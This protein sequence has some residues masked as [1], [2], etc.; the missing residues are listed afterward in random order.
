MDYRTDQ[1]KPPGNRSQPFVREADML[2]PIDAQRKRL[3][4]QNSM[5]W[6][7]FF[8]VQTMHGVVD[9]LF[10][11]PDIDAV[12]AR[13][14]VGVPAVTDSA[15]VATLLGLTALRAIKGHASR[16]ASIHALATLVP[17]SIA[18]LRR[19]VLPALV[20][21]GWA[22]QAND[23]AWLTMHAYEIPFKRIIAVEVKR[24]EWR[25]ALA[26][27]IPH[28]EFADTVYV[29]LDAAKIPALPRIEAAFNHAGIGLAAIKRSSCYP[30][31]NATNLEV[32]LRPRHQ[33][34]HGLVRAV[35]AERILALRAAGA[36]SGPVG[37]VFG[38][39][40]S[41]S[42]GSQ[43]PRILPVHRGE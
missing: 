12:A 29:A 8:E 18:H 17:V 43:D 41:T 15:Q 4:P 31:P 1:R 14:T 7:T 13:E 10:V 5:G 30:A 27:T 2:I 19:Y 35:V 21:S 9:M 39:F 28:T 26:Q 42:A 36:F 34:K 6:E 37:P 38:R 20:A 25:R 16:G 40:I 24:S 23:G 3:L 22:T 33:R 32:I 11:V